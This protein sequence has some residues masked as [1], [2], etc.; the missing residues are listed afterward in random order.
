MTDDLHQEFTSMTRCLI[1]IAVIFFG[2][3]GPLR[4]QAYLGPRKQGSSNMKIL[5]HVPLGGF[6]QINDIE[7]EQELA[8]PYVYV[9]R[10]KNAGF[11]VLNIK[12]LS[13]THII[14]SWQIENP[15]LHQGRSLGA[16]GPAYFKAKGRYYYAQSFQFD[17]GGPDGD[18]GAILFD[19]TSLPD[20]TKVKELARVRVPEAPNGFH[21]I[22]AY[23]HS[24]GRALMIATTN[25]PNANFYDVERLASGDAGLVVKIPVPGEARGN[26][27]WHDFY[28]GYDPSVHQDKF[29][30]SGTGGYYVFDI[31]RP[32]EFKLITS[33]T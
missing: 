27:S 12:D 14:Y 30:A 19:V 3:V 2:A 4:A 7:I 15:E 10:R 22:F 17:Q 28:A 6:F 21:E 9:S 23:K 26:T 11:Y 31:T 33:A 20:T 16:T 1:T 8:R 13:K 24:D 18:L 25:S 32:E 5:S 29:Y